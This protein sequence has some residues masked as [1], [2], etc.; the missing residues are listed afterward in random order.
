VNRVC[1]KCAELAPVDAVTCV[2]PACGA[3]LVMTV[4]DR[5][6]A[7]FTGGLRPHEKEAA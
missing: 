1:G 4:P 7:K 3:L 5:V 6:L 2:N